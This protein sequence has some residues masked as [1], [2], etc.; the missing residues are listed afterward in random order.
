MLFQRAWPVLLRL[1]RLG[2]LVA[3]LGWAVEAVD[4]SQSAN[5]FFQTALANWDQSFGR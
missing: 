1:F 2:I 3:L 4:V 5:A